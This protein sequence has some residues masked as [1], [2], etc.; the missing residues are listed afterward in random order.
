MQLERIV[1][2]SRKRNTAAPHESYGTALAKF[3][4]QEL[5]AEL[6]HQGQEDQEVENYKH[7]NR[8]CLSR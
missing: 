2:S 8:S 6:H 5:K 1:P 4:H 7:P 3:S